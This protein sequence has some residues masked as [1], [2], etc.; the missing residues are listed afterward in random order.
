MK[1]YSIG[2]FGGYDSVHKLFT[3]SFGWSSVMKPADADVIVWNGGADIGTEIY[4]E[5]SVMC[6]VPERQSYRDQMEI[7]MFEDFKNSGKLKLGI[8]RGAQL[9]NCL[10]GGKLYQ[11]VNNHTNS[12]L[13]L[14]VRTGEEI[15]ITSTHHQQMRAGQDATIIGIAND[16]TRKTSEEGTVTHA[17]AP[18]IKDGKDLEIVWYPDTQTLCIQGH[19]EYVPGSRFAK[20]TLELITKL[21]TPVV[22][23]IGELE[24][25]D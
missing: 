25:A 6:G 19:P 23:F 12:H 20:Y 13:M 21:Y 17:Q 4:G 3:D 5:K 24:C 16:S 1:F 11:D 8:C 14:D 2:D 7:G 22:S 9:L 10:N 15:Q 18:S